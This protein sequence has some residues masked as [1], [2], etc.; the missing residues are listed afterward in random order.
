MATKLRGCLE[1]L[2]IVGAAGTQ[3]LL[4]DKELL[5]RMLYWGQTE[6]V[7][8]SLP[9]EDLIRILLDMGPGQLTKI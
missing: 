1:T 9:A 7:T 8:L 3:E 4:P 6:T 2:S 5:A